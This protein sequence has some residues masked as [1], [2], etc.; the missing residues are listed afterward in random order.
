MVDPGD[1]KGYES[2]FYGPV[3][4]PVHTGSGDI[5]Y[6][7]TLGGGEEVEFNATQLEVTYFDLILNKSPHLANT[8]TPLG[9]LPMERL[10]VMPYV[11]PASWVVGD[12]GGSRGQAAPDMP[13]GGAEPAMEAVRRLKRT[14]IFGAPGIGKTTFLKFV[15]RQMAAGKVENSFPVFLSLYTYAT[16]S[17]GRDLLTFALENRFSMLYQGKELEALGRLLRL[18][19]REGKLVFLLDGLDEVPAARRER[20]LRQIQSLPR[21]VL[22]SRPAGRVDANQEPD[23][24][25][26]LLPL[27]DGGVARFVRK[28]EE[29]QTD[30]SSSDQF[31]AAELFDYI[32]GESRLV[33]LAR[34]PQLLSLI[35][36]LWG[37]GRTYRYRTKADLLAGAVDKLI[38]KAMGQSRL[39]SG[40]WELLHRDLRRCL[41]RLAFDMLRDEHGAR[42][43]LPT[44]EALDFFEALSNREVAG[45]LMRLA[46]RSGLLVPTTGRA[47]ELTFW[48]LVFQEYLA[49]EALIQQED[50]GGVIDAVKHRSEFEECLRMASAL[51][52]HSQF[53]KLWPRLPILVERLLAERDTDIFRLNWR[54]AALCLAEVDDPRRR[55]GPVV[56]RLEAGLLECASEWW[57]RDRFAEA[58]GRLRTDGMRARLV[59]ALQHEDDYVRWA[60]S[61]A[62]GHM[63]DPRTV[64]ALL[65]RLDVEDWHAVRGSLIKALGQIGDRRAVP[66][67]LCLIDGLTLHAFFQ[68]QA[69][70]E[71]LGRIGDVEALESLLSRLETEDE[72]NYWLVAEV[73]LS[74]MPHL[75]DEAAAALQR[76]LAERGLTVQFTPADRFAAPGPTLEELRQVLAS[77]DVEARQKA[78]V[79]LGQ[80]GGEWAFW[81]LL[82]ALLDEDE[83][84]WQA[85]G[86]ALRE[87]TDEAAALVHAVGTLAHYLIQEEDL[88]GRNM[89]AATL[90][91]LWM[92][93]SERDEIV[94]RRE[95]ITGMI[96]EMSAEGTLVALLENENEIVRGAAAWL[97][98]LLGGA[99]HLGGLVRLLDDE[100]SE[101]PRWSAAWA[102]GYLEKDGG[103]AVPALVERARQDEVLEVVEAAIKSLGMLKAPEAVPLL[104]EALYYADAVLRRTAAES[105]GQIGKPDAVGPL[106]AA[107]GDD[108]AD[109]RLAVIRALGA[110]GNAEATSPLMDQLKKEEAEIRAAAASALGQIGSMEAA[111]ALVE[112]LRLD[113]EPQVRIAAAGA[114]G[115]VG[116]GNAGA[117]GM[118]IESLVS[119][120]PDLRRAAA[121]SLGEIGSRAAIPQLVHMLEN[122]SDDSCRREAGTAFAKVADLAAIL[123]LVDRL[124]DGHDLDRLDPI[125][126]VL[127]D[128]ERRGWRR[129]IL[130]R[131]ADKEVYVRIGRH[132]DLIELRGG[133]GMVRH[134]VGAPGDQIEDPDVDP[135]EH[136]IDDLLTAPYP[137]SRWEAADALEELK[138]ERAVGPLIASLLDPDPWV[139]LRAAEAL[140]GLYSEEGLTDLVEAQCAQ[141]LEVLREQGLL[142]DLIERLLGE[143]E[144][145]SMVDETAGW[146]LGRVQVLCDLIA[147]YAQGNAWGRSPLWTISDRHNLRVMPDGSVILPTGQKVVCEDAVSRLTQW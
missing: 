48:H 132:R 70:G 34:V 126:V 102:L 5:Y 113:D 22:T 71:A 143:D 55:L 17:D 33:E 29:W 147:A 111:S 49:A 12:R 114:L 84:V 92:L 28:W 104:V 125:C 21:F 3:S 50:F 141:G 57:A 19:H 134:G 65:A 26:D 136:F 79:A 61:E 40:E 16:E 99:A 1:D 101:L 76:M 100:A 23:G 45:H 108:T 46:R 20:L 137:N 138:S 98:G 123:A 42:L 44:S 27:D 7:V 11:A 95:A 146:V 86:E 96:R 129:E 140:D 78:V 110:I 121:E 38:G 36:S 24:T 25:L 128:R 90:M 53:S 142:P 4:G 18:W 8:S 10:Y 15:T 64:D 31:S 81:N 127:L 107:L 63:A 83:D 47:D 66:V 67:L 52:S 80:M 120:G 41:A 93:R 144:I 30:R 89:A 54:L 37:K 133:W 72:G 35:C 56:D 43:T 60:A 115:R 131:L 116:K 112:M 118:L 106:V 69:V 124:G 91:R 109:V 62:L 39:P 130:K 117:E 94:R 9:S 13:V 2:R 139:F 74:A 14:V 6:R 77:E 82:D 58:M 135:V 103:R 87:M 51:L 68:V 88:E 59:E 119:P 75:P 85:A 122:D 145:A 105:L 32:Q 97:L 73:I